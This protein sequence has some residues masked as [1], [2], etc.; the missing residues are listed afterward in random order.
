MWMGEK[1]ME[2]NDTQ[3]VSVNRHKDK[4]TDYRVMIKVSTILAIRKKE[5]KKERKRNTFVKC[6]NNIQRKFMKDN[7][8]ICFT[9][10]PIRTFISFYIRAPCALRCRKRHWL[11]FPMKT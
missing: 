10:G 11:P 5:R 3:V 9:I 1:Q 6:Q 7:I 4:R 8:Q 2:K